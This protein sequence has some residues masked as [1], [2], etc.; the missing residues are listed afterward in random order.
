MT[1]AHRLNWCGVVPSRSEA[2]VVVC[3]AGDAALVVRTRPRLLV[4]GCP[5]GCGEVLPINLDER[6]GDAWRLYQGPRGAS[7]Y[8]SVWRETGCESHFIIWRGEIFFFGRYDDEQG[9]RDSEEPLREVLLATL[10]R[11]ELTPFASL[12]EGLDVVPWDVLTVCRRLVR[13]GL[14][15]EGSGN[16]RG[17]F[18]LF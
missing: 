14:V 11:E 9:L 12:A 8:P 10:S 17:C 7:L 13:E 2:G 1:G 15:R 6:A 4:L 3:T 16:R 5:C 18:A